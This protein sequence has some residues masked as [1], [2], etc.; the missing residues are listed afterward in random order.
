MTR[1]FLLVLCFLVLATA[2]AQAGLFRRKA[3][4]PVPCQGA[5]C[6]PRVAHH[7]VRPARRA[8]HTLAPAGTVPVTHTYS[9][10]S[11]AYWVAPVQG[12]SGGTCPR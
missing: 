5:A 6:Q 8:P 2:D 1:Y 11:A 4:R 7:A 9:R 12:C 3:H 10:T